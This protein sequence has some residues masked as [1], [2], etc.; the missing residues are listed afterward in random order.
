MRLSEAAREMGSETIE[1]EA[2]KD[3]LLPDTG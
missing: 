2:E 3:A 1:R